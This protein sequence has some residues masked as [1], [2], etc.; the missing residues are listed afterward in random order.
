MRDLRGQK[1]LPGHLKTL[2]HPGCLN[3]KSLSHEEPQ[4]FLWTSL[5]PFARRTRSKLVQDSEG[6]RLQKNPAC[7]HIP[8]SLGAFLDPCSDLGIPRWPEKDL[9]ELSQPWGLAA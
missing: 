3:S 5:P 2:S 4:N 9:V 7:L 1:G 8:N 6:L